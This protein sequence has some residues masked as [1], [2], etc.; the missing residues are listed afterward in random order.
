M[1]SIGSRLS[2]LNPNAAAF[3]PAS[4]R[5]ASGESSVSF[6]HDMSH[7]IP[8]KTTQNLST[9]QACN[10]KSQ[11]EASSSGAT[12]QG[13]SQMLD[14][15]SEMDLD[16]L[17]MQFSN[18]SDQSLIDAYMFHG[19]DVDA[20]MDMLNYLEVNFCLPFLWYIALWLLPL[21]LACQVTG[22]I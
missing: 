18:V 15:E 11:S 12:V 17:R 19:R 9:S 1:S 14:D 2:S 4:K 8:Q 13:E 22:N 5:E 7:G 21:L 3:V 6:N 10:V 16:F 20:T